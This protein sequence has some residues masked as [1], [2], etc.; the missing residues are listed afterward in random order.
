MATVIPEADAPQSDGLPSDVD[1]DQVD[2][3]PVVHDGDGDPVSDRTGRRPATLRANRRRQRAIS[4]WTWVMS[5]GALLIAFAL[6]QLYGTAIAESHSQDSLAQQFNAEVH[7]HHGAK[8]LTL[9]PA[10]AQLPAPPEG[11]V[12]ALIQIPKIGVDKYVVSGTNTDDLAKGPGH[13]TGTALPGQYGNVA[14]AGHRTTH[15]APF[16]RLAELSRGDHIYLTDLAGQRLD[17]VVVTTPFP[18][19]PSNTSVLNYFGDNRLTLTT[20]NPEF[21]A[22]QRL[23]V[24][25]GYVGPGSTGAIHPLTTDGSG[26]PYDVAIGGEAGWNTNMVPLVL[27][28]G[29]L[30]V[31]LGLTNRRWSRILGRESRWLVLVPIWTALI[32]ALFEALS[33]FLPAAA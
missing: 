33:N 27:L 32:Y 15:G 23:I 10:A 31:A 26:R 16:N 1:A 11:S 13:Y 6:W 30:L 20:C 17:Y 22:A 18:V 2:A 19:S 8:G 5:I 29:V 28:I 24:V 9:L 14:I 12:M 3:D 21:S 7:A 25:A 4:F